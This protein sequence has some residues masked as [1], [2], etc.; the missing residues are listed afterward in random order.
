MQV[1]KYL[2]K[3]ILFGVD[4]FLFVVSYVI[5]Y[6]IRFKYMDDGIIN[7]D[8][9]FLLLVICILYIVIIAFVKWPYYLKPAKNTRYIYLILKTHIYL[10]FGLFSMLFVF[11]SNIDLSRLHIMI[12]LVASFVMCSTI[13]VGFRRYLFSLVKR[14]DSGEKV[15]LVCSMTDVKDILAD[16]STEDNWYYQISGIAICDAET[17]DKYI[18]KI[19]V[20]TYKDGLLKHI[21]KAEADAVF[22]YGDADCDKQHKELIK[23]LIS[24]G[25]TTY[26][27]ISEARYMDG[28]GYADR[29]VG[30]PVWTY[31]SKQNIKLYIVKRVGD[32]MFGVIG[33]IIYLVTFLPIALLIKLCS[34]GPVLVPYIKVGRNGKRFRLLKYRTLGGKKGE[35][36][37]PAGKTLLHTRL[38][39]LPMFLLLLHGELSLF[40]KKALSLQEFLDCDAN[41]RKN[42]GTKPGLIQTWFCDDECN[43]EQ[44]I[45]IEDW[46]LNKCP[47]EIDN[48]VED[49]K[50][51]YH[52]LKR[53][54]DIVISLVGIV[55]LSPVYIVIL[56]AVFLFDGHSPIYTQVRVGKSGKKINIYKF[57]TM[58]HLAG[59][60]E[61]LLTS[62][63][64][65]RYKREYKLEDDPRVTK[66]GNILRKTSLD[67]LPQL[68]NVLKGDISL[69]GPRPIVES[70]LE[71]YGN[72]V[73]KLL[74]VKPGL[75]G[76]WQAYRR[77]LAKYESGERQEMELSYVDRESFFFDIKIVIKTIGTVSSGKGSM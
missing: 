7:V 63:Q 72:D 21:L 5:A 1:K 51:L 3:L 76:Y 45:Y 29:I 60:L 33:S 12:S 40:G 37:N 35:L 42:M 67:E 70:E 14:S 49:K 62:E 4:I 43:R 16:M 31:T 41:Q 38:E 68:F 20:I 55:L 2:L 56:L 44:E 34:R 74:S 24:A 71:Y 19:P 10:F 53:F 77:N 57:R 25:I 50:C 73:A 48:K 27:H 59:D 26:V 75:T 13:G 9:G 6:L 54:M 39:N 52:I 28:D 17:G 61:R 47:V 22:V 36:Q 30:Y 69:V 64:L 65:E 46:W 18:Q 23:G 11:K 58:H 66:I 15:I 8:Y 32:I